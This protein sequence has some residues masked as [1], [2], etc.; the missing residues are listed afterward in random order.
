VETA[1]DT[2]AAKICKHG[3]CFGEEDGDEALVDLGS[4]GL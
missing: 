2:G 3:R 1:D 4:A